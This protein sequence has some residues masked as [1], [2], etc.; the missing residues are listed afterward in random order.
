MNKLSALPLLLVLTS[1][2]TVP[3][4]PLNDHYEQ[5]IEVPGSSKDI[6][7]AATNAWFVE[8][9]NSAESVI[10]FQDKKAGRVMGKYRFPGSFMYRT[11]VSVDVRDDAARIKFYDLSYWDVSIL[12]GQGQWKWVSSLNAKSRHYYLSRDVIPKWHKM[13]ASFETRLKESRLKES[14]DW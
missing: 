1:C 10:Q 7:Y 3:D 9:F 12:S 11:L 2:V 8:R 6:L 13:A 14:D 5:V 4:V